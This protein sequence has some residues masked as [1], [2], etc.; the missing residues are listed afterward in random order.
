[1]LSEPHCQHLRRQVRAA[2][3]VV[4]SLIRAGS[5]RAPERSMVA[6]LRLDKLSTTRSASVDA[7]Y[8]HDFPEQ[9][10]FPDLRLT[11]GVATLETGPPL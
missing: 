7:G 10:N 9:R 8:G 5:I 3:V 11:R 1:V 4:E 2:E 6:C